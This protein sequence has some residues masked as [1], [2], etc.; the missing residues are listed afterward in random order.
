MRRTRL[1]DTMNYVLRLGRGRVPRVLINA[2]F[3]V[4]RQIVLLL[5]HRVIQV[6]IQGL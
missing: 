2:P 6:F 4:R 1:D 5:F 3:N